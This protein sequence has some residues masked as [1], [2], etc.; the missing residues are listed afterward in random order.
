MTDHSSGD[1]SVGQQQFDEILAELMRAIDAGESVDR[2]E[3]IS[4]GRAE[5][6][7]REARPS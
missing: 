3:W 4:G 1:T 2:G 7:A 5:N 6:C